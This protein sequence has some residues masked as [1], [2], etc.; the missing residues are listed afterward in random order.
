M[1]GQSGAVPWPFLAADI[2]A[3]LERLR[4]SVAGAPQP[5]NAAKSMTR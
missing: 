5:A 1:M 2:P 4:K 3:A